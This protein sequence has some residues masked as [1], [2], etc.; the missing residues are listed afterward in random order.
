M[1]LVVRHRGRAWG[2]AE[3]VIM[4]VVAAV[5]AQAK[6]IRPARVTV[7]AAGRGMRMIA[8]VAV[9]VV[10]AEGVVAAVVDRVGRWVRAVVPGVPTAG[11]RMRVCR[12]SRADILGTEGMKGAIV[13]IVVLV[14]SPV[15][16]ASARAAW[17]RSVRNGVRVGTGSRVVRL[18]E[19]RSRVLL[20]AKP[21]RRVCNPKN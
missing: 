11:R 19:V 16:R 8:G 21:E 18:R 17:G 13:V 5:R 3:V 9:V 20:Q 4:A 12:G 10:G 6:T 2:M 15:G 7:E 1:G 14:P